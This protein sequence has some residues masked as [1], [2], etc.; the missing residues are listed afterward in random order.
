MW[1]WGKSLV[2]FIV[3]Q[4]RISMGGE[5]SLERRGKLKRR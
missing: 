4:S 2:K 5:I 1:E 3:R